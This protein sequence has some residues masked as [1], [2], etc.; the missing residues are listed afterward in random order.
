MQIDYSLFELKPITQLNRLKRK[1][2]Q[3]VFFRVEKKFYLEY[4][5]WEEFGDHS[6][7]YVLDSIKRTKKLPPVLNQQLRL[8]KD[9]KDIEKK[10]FKN[11]LLVKP[12]E[13]IQM[14]SG[15]YKVKYLGELNVLSK[16][17]SSLNGKV[18]LD[19]NN[20]LDEKTFLLFWNSLSV[21]DKE[22]I[23][24][25]EDPCCFSYKVWSKFDSAG[26]PLANDFNPY[27]ATICR[28]TVFKP[29]RNEFL[30]RKNQIFSSY[31]GAELG[32]YH[33]YLALMLWGDTSL[34]HGIVTNDIYS[35]QLNLF[36]KQDEQLY[37]LQHN[38]VEKMY[39]QLEERE[40]KN[41]I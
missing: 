19:F 33:A 20:A 37:S 21:G 13:S 40:W 17:I 23:E 27:Q 15:V 8:E 38:L 26:V 30:P 34:Y 36:K 35:N 31:M 12:H 39:S 10:V 14:I 4:F 16:F 25:V 3:G 2:F 1:K 22:K 28:F 29:N 24:F 32:Q 5:P 18:R 7:D 9:Q 41:L 6:C 11:H